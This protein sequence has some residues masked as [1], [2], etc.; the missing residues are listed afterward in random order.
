[1]AYY[2]YWFRKRLRLFTN[3]LA[4]LEQYTYVQTDPDVGLATTYPA[5]H[6][7]RGAKRSKQA[8]LIQS[9]SF[10]PKSI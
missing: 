7:L 9:P 6:A 8:F 5:Y 3:V 2:F 4:D 10:H 1:M